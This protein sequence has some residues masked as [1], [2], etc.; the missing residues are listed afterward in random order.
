MVNTV[1]GTCGGSLS[2]MAFT[3]NPISE[4]CTVDASFKDG[5]LTSFLLPATYCRASAPGDSLGLQFKEWGLVNTNLDRSVA[6]TCGIPRLLN[7]G[8]S[9]ATSS[10]FGLSL[11]ARNV[12]FGNPSL[13]RILCKFYEQTDEGVSFIDDINVSL[14]ETGDTYHALGVQVPVSAIS[15]YILNCELPSDTA[16]SAIKVEITN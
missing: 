15:N 6:V 1:H 12:S 5:V 9:I 4:D 3:T 16:I 8:G 10:Q 7:R 11:S 14:D 13:Q 2:G